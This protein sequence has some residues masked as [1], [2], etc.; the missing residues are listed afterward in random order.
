M[1]FSR[2]APSAQGLRANSQAANRLSCGCKLQLGSTTGCQP[3]RESKRVRRRISP[4]TGNSRAASD[5]CSG[6]SKLGT[7]SSIKMLTGQTRH[8]AAAVRRTHRTLSTRSPDPFRSCRAHQLRSEYAERNAQANDGA[9]ADLETETIRK[10]AGPSRCRS[11]PK[12]RRH[13]WLSSRPPP[14]CKT[15]CWP[16]CARKIARI[17]SNACW[18]SRR[19]AVGLCGTQG[20]SSGFWHIGLIARWRHALAFDAYRAR[21]R[22][23]SRFNPPRK[24]VSVHAGLPASSIR[25]IR[26]SSSRKNATIS[27]LARCLPMH[28]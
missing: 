1:N 20:R 25:S 27:A 2:L 19:H 11:R 14:N 12:A 10:T 17:F 9:K 18:R 5:F 16:P 24:E 13:F 7:T 8:H 15:S 23:G 6:C 26:A 21:Y 3:T 28:A 22:T 4:A